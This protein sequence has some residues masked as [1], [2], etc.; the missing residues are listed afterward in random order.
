MHDKSH[1]FSKCSNLKVNGKLYCTFSKRKRR[2]SPSARLQQ[3]DVYGQKEHG[4]KSPKSRSRTIFV[5]GQS[6]NH[7]TLPIHTYKSPKSRSW[8]I[9]CVGTINQS[10][11]FSHA[12]VCY[13]VVSGKSVIDWLIDV[14]VRWKNRKFNQV[15]PFSMSRIK[16]RGLSFHTLSG[17][18][19]LCRLVIQYLTSRLTRIH[20]LLLGEAMKRKNLRNHRRNRHQQGKRSTC[21]KIFIKKLLPDEEVAPRWKKRKN[22]WIC[23]LSD[24]HE[25][26]LST[27]CIPGSCCW[28][29]D[30]LIKTE[31]QTIF[32]SG[33]FPQKLLITL[34]SACGCIMILCTGPFET[35]KNKNIK[36]FI[37]KI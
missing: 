16:W 35:S 7:S 34:S 21:D 12:L 22:C 31:H 5:P 25:Y 18:F 26:R 37:K 4:Y 24:P 32:F 1:T 14:I 28:S 2:F 23:D 15:Y 10:I 9:F 11:N 8:T 33:C 3:R 13:Q 19:S 30:C 17:Y 20:G 6:I 27:D 36:E 29:I